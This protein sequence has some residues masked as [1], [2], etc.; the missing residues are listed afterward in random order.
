MIVSRRS[1]AAQPAI[2]LVNEK[3]EIEKSG[4][5][6]A[7]IQ[8]LPLPPEYR[9]LIKNDVASLA[10]IGESK[11]KWE[12]IEA[13]KAVPTLTTINGCGL[14]LYGRGR[15]EPKPEWFFATQYFVMLFIPIVPIKRYL[16]SRAPKG[17][18]YFH[19]T[20]KFTKGPQN[21]FMVRLLHSLPQQWCF[22]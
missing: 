9:E 10:N 16:V 19:G 5:L 20:A 2:D 3:N 18:W 11:A 21:L 15:F 6:L 12:G 8:E 14:T 1:H 17:G 22:L 7:R 13:I 4:A